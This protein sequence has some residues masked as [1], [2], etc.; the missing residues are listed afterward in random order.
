MSSLNWV[1]QCSQWPQMTSSGPEFPDLE[2]GEFRLELNCDCNALTRGA[3][4]QITIRGP[5][6]IRG[7]SGVRGS[8]CT[9]TK[10]GS[11]VSGVSGGFDLKPQDRSSFPMGSVTLRAER[12]RCVTP[13]CCLHVPHEFKRDSRYLRQPAEVLP[14]PGQRVAPC[15]GRPGEPPGVRLLC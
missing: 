7:G 14:Y 10:R 13:R 6:R 11:R 9:A 5:L 3:R 4:E 12:L 8:C 1:R 2:T 15:H